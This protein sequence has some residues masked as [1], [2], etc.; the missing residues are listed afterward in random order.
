MTRG[1]LP[2]FRTAPTAA[3]RLQGR[4]LGLGALFLFIYALTLSLSPIGRL[5]SWTT[6]LRW[7]HWLGFGVWLVL[8][9]LAHLQTARWL[10]DR[11]PFLLPG[12][13]L[14]TGWGLL[15]VWRLMPTFGLRQTVWLLISFIF[16]ILAL[17][18]PPDLNFLRRYKYLWLTSGLLLTALT[19]FFGTNPAGPEF[20]RLWLGCCGLYFQPSEPLKLL[21][22]IYLA[23]YLAGSRG[24]QGSPLPALTSRLLP[25]LAPTMIMTGIALLLLVI[26]R[27]LGTASI[28]LFLYTTVVYVTTG[29]PRI[30]MLGLL[31]V[32]LAGT[33]GYL[34]FDV[35]RLR[36]DAWINPWLDPSGRSYQ[37][38]Q[39][40]IAVANGGLFG[41][42]PGMGSPGLVPVPH[43]DFIFAAL[44]EETGL[45][46]VVGFL[47]LLALLVQRGIRTALRAET[48]FQR[49]LAA[50]LTAFLA[51][52]SILIIGGNLRMLPLTGVT[53]PFV[54]YG[55][56]SLL[57]SFFSL[58]LLLHI[59][60]TGESQPAPLANARPYLQLGGFL[61]AGLGAASLVTGWWTVIRGPE[62]LNRTDNPRRA[63]AD[64]FVYRGALLDRNDRP[65]ARTSGQP[66]E[67]TREY[68]YPPLSPIL[69]Y[70]NPVYGLSA[71]E[72][73]LDPYLRGQQGNEVL[74]VWWNQL[75]YGQPPPGRDIR[76]T[77]DLPLQRSAD[78]L[79]GDT[80]GAILLLEA[81]RGE[82]L[83]MASHPYFDANRLEE[84][85]ENIIA[86][87]AGPLLNRAVQ[88]LYLLGEL[89]P[90]LFPQGLDTPGI[91]EAPQLRLPPID[92][93]DLQA[94]NL[95]LS[96]L[97][98]A[99][100][101]AALS[102]EGQRPSA[103]LVEA[104]NL[105]QT[106]WSRLP[107]L[108]E[109][110]QVFTP[111]AATE[112]A[113]SLALPGLPLWGK[114]T[115]AAGPGDRSATWFVGG[116][117]PGMEGRSLALAV[118]IEIEDPQLAQ[119]IGQELLLNALNTEGN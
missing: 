32:L 65:L 119:S 80:P 36:I 19:L 31:G 110:V 97:Q 81:R 26:Q 113:N 58:L 82:I 83:V 87:Q 37:I 3:N 118:L 28:F 62:L 64:N 46:G 106:G 86:D 20:P 102:E 98:V 115:I 40:L 93:P 29:K 15:E 5:R 61:I 67:Y 1:K 55:G 74:T 50:G 35:V 22:V 88:G 69:G 43:S 101:A 42:G 2:F 56:S 104:V 75:L 30:L 53:L 47:A 13:A 23:A 100:A 78:T 66:G 44:A 109:Q 21:L 9:I 91:T 89:E 111:E 49:Y 57:T 105:Q 39:S 33:A 94:G 116:T 59:S 48:R 38:V 12:A 54:S 10:P 76:L 92:S 60:S 70:S 77:I 14:L 25:L 95:T 41:R 18:L 11:D 114:T 34:L 63:I 52:Q 6:E 73:S 90:L 71:L 16:F 24:G 4:M 117:L 107:P 7:D 84:D 99:L 51:G 17:R 68:L 72:E 45:A 79:L 8:I 96:P 112:A 103:Y 85:W 27:D 108:D